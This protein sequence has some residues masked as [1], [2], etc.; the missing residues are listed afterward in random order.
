MSQWGSIL[1]AAVTAIA[2]TVGVTGAE[3]GLRE[4]DRVSTGDRPHAFIFSPAED[5]ENLDWQQRLRKLQ[6]TVA[7]VT[8]GAQEAALILRDAMIATLE[9]D[10][11]LAALL[12]SISVSS[13]GIDEHTAT[14]LKT[15]LLIVQTERVT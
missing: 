5:V 13:S 6:F 7:L 12:D 2:G 8:D 15:V 3:R 9:S 1:D 11:G 10:A 14:Q 4:L